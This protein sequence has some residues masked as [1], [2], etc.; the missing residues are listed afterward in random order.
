MHHRP[1]DDPAKAEGVPPLPDMDR[2]A[3]NRIPGSVDDPNL[4]IRLPQLVNTL[5]GLL[6][7]RL[8]GPFDLINDRLNSLEVVS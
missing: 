3:R 2:H 8:G 7:P 5:V 6:T 1:V 4:Q